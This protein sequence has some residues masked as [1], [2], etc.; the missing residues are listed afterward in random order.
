MHVA[1]AVALMRSSYLILVLYFFSSIVNSMLDVSVM[2]FRGFGNG[3][4]FMNTLDN[5]LVTL[6]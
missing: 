6:T 2:P 3:I 4:L 5:T 1:D